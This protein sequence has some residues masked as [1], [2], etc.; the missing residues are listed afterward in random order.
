MRLWA[1][2]RRFVEARRA[3]DDSLLVV[4]QDL[5]A[6]EYEYGVRIDAADLPRLLTALGADPGADPLDALAARGEEV[7]SRGERRWFDDHH[8]PATAWSLHDE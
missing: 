1:G 7:V 8:V 3:D 6:A 5:T 2:D 4:G